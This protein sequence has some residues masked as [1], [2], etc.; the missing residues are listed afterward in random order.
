MTDDEEAKV[1]NI[2]HEIVSEHR[3]TVDDRMNL[4][5]KDLTDMRGEVHG[6]RS[7][8]HKI[9]NTVSEMN[10]SLKSIATNSTVVADMVNTYTK[11]KNFWDV[12]TWFKD[13]WFAF[14]LLAAILFVSAWMMGFKVMF[15]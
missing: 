10:L 8:I 3:E 7:D 15:E 4:M 2:V 6:L 1:R 14:A 11:V 13:N 5:H 12:V 9:T